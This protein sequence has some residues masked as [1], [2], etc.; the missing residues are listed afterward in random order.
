LHWGEFAD[1]FKVAMA[2]DRIIALDLPGNGGLHQE[3]SPN[4]VGEM[5]THC[6]GQLAQQGIAP[7]YS[8]LAMSLGG[9][10]AVEWAARNPQ[11]VECSVLINTSMRPF[12]PFYER[13][14]VN[15]FFV[16]LKL[17]MLR[18]GPLKWELAV[19]HATSNL[20]SATVV[21]QWMALRHR[22]PVSVRNAVRQLLAA[23]KFRAHES[24][25]SGPIL[26]LASR[27]DHLVSVQCSMALARH[28][29]CQIQLH[30][31]AGH[32]LP[33]DDGPWVA[34]RVQQWVLAMVGQENQ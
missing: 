33:L 2:G 23:A 6:R 1:Q 16:F 15:C 5:V 28:W 29:G 8:L 31:T 22:Q 21:A 4:S 3:E 18:A 32:D 34:Q 19:W 12:S 7:P 25:P 26:V 17:G 9:M 24:K 10:V 20:S 13:M 14:N 30:L 11:E 27:E